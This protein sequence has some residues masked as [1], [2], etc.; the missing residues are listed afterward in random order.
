MEWNG[1][2][3]ETENIKV[4]SLFIILCPHIFSLIFATNVINA[5]YF[6]ASYD[7]IY[8]CHV[9]LIYGF[10][11]GILSMWWLASVC[12]CFPRKSLSNCLKMDVEI[13]ASNLDLSHITSTCTG[14]HTLTHI[15]R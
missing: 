11:N 12:D 14:P 3:C 1:I 10:L 5:L 13:L 9:K 2:E 7:K 8:N 4:I 6:K 15:M